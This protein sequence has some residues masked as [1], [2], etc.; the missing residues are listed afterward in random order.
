MEYVFVPSFFCIMDY[1]P[2]LSGYSMLALPSDHWPEEKMLSSI[3]RKYKPLPCQ[4]HCYSSPLA[5]EYTG[6]TLCETIFS[7]MVVSINK[8]HVPR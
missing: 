4:M 7:G 8:S 1:G 6:I 3:T 2:Y 5:V